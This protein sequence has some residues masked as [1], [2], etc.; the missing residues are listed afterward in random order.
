MR[1]VLYDVDMYRL[2]P[3][4][5]EV[6]AVSIKIPVHPISFNEAKDIVKKAFAASLEVPD[7]RKKI[8]LTIGQ[9]LYQLSL[10]TK[11]ALT[12]NHEVHNVVVTIP[13]T[14]EPDRYVMIG[15][16]FDS[17]SDGAYD[18]AAG[19]AALLAITKALHDLYEQYRW[20]P[21]RTIIL[22]FWDAHEFGSIGATEFNE[23][24]FI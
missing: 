22:A 13:G 9:E 21:R 14:V 19:S 20:R 18:S 7:Q 3:Q 12:L 15:A 24:C 2:N 16:H 6:A 11:E 23:V 10:I 17:F 5:D 4:S 1:L 8:H